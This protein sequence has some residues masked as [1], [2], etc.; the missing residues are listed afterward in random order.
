M[1]IGF[2]KDVSAVRSY[3]L[4]CKDGVAVTLT[5]T[6]KERDLCIILT[7]DFKFSAQSSRAASKANAIL[8]MLKHTFMSIET[9]SCGL[10]CIERIFDRI[11]SSLTRLGA[12]SFGVI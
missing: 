3:S 11:S 12:H 6:V 8:G 9:S 7:P 2:K 4:Q 5:H 1:N 10:C